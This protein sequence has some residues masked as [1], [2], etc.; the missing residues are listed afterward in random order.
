MWISL[1]VTEELKSMTEFKCAVVDYTD[2]MYQK[3]LRYDKI[4]RI[5][6][7]KKGMSNDGRKQIC[8]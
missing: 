7:K 5:F 2:F 6:I 1:V 3:V 4:F 8:H